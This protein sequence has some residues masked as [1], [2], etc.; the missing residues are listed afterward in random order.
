MGGILDPRAGFRDVFYKTQDFAVRSALRG[1]VNRHRHVCVRALVS[2]EIDQHHFNERSVMKKILAAVFALFFASAVMAATP[3]KEA[4]P[5][6]GAK[7]A[8]HKI[9]KHKYHHKMVMHKKMKAHKKVEKKA[10]AAK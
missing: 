5:T 1:F 2:L 4:K 7:P 8:A 9:V 6:E 3:V 10:P